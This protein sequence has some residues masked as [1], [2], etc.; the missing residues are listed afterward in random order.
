[1]K[2]QK[3]L[4][5]ALI[6]IFANCQSKREKIIG[7]WLNDDPESEKITYY[8]YKI[9]SSFVRYEYKEYSKV[10]KE[11]DKKMWDFKEKGK[12]KWYINNDTLYR[13][14][15]NNMY[16]QEL[17]DNSLVYTSKD[18]QY[19][20][21][22]VKTTKEE[23]TSGLNE[24]L[25]RIEARRLNRI[26]EEKAEL[27]SKID[28][29]Y[30]K[31]RGGLYVDQIKFGNGS[32]QTNLEAAKLEFTNPTTRIIG[33]YKIKSGKSVDLYYGANKIGY[34]DFYASNDDDISVEI[35]VNRYGQ[36]YRFYAS[37]K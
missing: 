20:F 17:N 11:I 2:T 12:R 14:H 21:R 24:L 29:L 6:F 8:E 25:K 1:M 31:V 26:E 35:V 16:I 32:F 7:K 19:K 23:L 22:L 10:F 34:V 36:S 28:G 13:E 4:F 33:T 27:E 15:Y 18:G 30:E 9:D 37:R 5:I 3:L